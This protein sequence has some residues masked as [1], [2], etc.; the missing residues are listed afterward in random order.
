MS[1]LWINTHSYIRHINTPIWVGQ[2]HKAIHIRVDGRRND[3]EGCRTQT[4]VSVQGTRKK[5]LGFEIGNNKLSSS[6]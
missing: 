3:K 4:S 5:L 2:G 1:E 6:M